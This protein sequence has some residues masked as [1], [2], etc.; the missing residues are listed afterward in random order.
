[1]TM[2]RKSI[3]GLRGKTVLVMAAASLIVMGMLAYCPAANAKNANPG[4]LPPNSHPYGM[5]YADWGDVW[6]RWAFSIPDTVNPLTD[7]TGEDATEGQSGNVWFLAG[8]MGG[9]YERTVTVPAGKALFFPVVNYVYVNTP[10]YGDNPWS[11][12]QEAYCRQQC[13]EAINSMV[14]TCEID[15]QAVSNLA[16]Y[17]CATPEGKAYMIDFCE[18]NIWGL[19]AGSYGPTVEEGI[20]LMLAPPNVGE[21]TI[22]FTAASDAWGWSLDVTYHITVAGRQAKAVA[23]R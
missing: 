7:V 21:H 22:H 13:S 19:P 16:A 15:G 17:R 8:G 4:I 1:M 14:V 11:D 3:F 6:W 20:Y 5:S 23:A 2:Q 9:T 18:G 12:E 10:D